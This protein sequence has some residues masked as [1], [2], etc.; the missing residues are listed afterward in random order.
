MCVCAGLYYRPAGLKSLTVLEGN[1]DKRVV[2]KNFEL[3]NLH[4]NKLDF[5]H[6]NYETYLK[7]NYFIPRDEKNY[8]AHATTNIL[9]DGDGSLTADKGLFNIFP[10]DLDSVQHKNARSSSLGVV[11]TSPLRLEVEFS[12]VPLDL[13]WYL[14]FTYAYT[15]KVLFTGN[16]AKQDVQ[17][18]VL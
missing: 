4:V 15:N 18:S 7:R 16:K 6:N 13:T 1:T 9:P 10:V 12:N 14:C 11:T 3:D 2:F 8:W 17:F 5:T